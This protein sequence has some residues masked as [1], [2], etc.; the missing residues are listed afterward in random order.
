MSTVL[1]T[2]ATG[3]L[4]NVLVRELVNCGQRIRVLVHPRDN[5]HALQMLPIEVVYGDVR[6]D[7]SDALFG[8][9]TI[10][11]LASIISITP[12]RRKQLYSVNVGG[13]QNV[14]SLAK[15]YKIPLIY[16]SSVHAFSEMG[17]GSIITEE[18]PIDES[19]TIG[20]YAKSKTMATKLVFSAF[21][22]G[23]N[24]FIIFPTGIFG[25]YDFKN[26][27]FSNVMRKYHEGK[28]KITVKGKFDFVD[29]RD[30]VH[31]M[32]ELYK[33][34]ISDQRNQIVN[35]EGFIISGNDI[36][37]E[38]LP[39]LC[40]LSNYRILGDSLADFVSYLSLFGTYLSIPSEFVPYALHTIRLD[41]KFSHDKV[42]K[43]T[44]YAPREVEESVN[45]FFNWLN[46]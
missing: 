33:Q 25:P 41:C 24:G 21:K 42:S 9:E 3:H 11:H 34:F 30:L 23:L 28:L 40:G 14:I 22:E 46:G 8:V 44:N 12:S 36:Y 26:S 6:D 35:G 1:V 27:Y 39:R 13:T 20:D 5:L 17:P 19:R 29:V 7:F 10:F 43:I 45:D 15:M 16:V 4:G 2:G 37:F 32:V 38:E 18:T 31:A